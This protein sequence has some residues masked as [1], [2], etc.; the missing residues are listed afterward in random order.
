MVAHTPATATLLTHDT[1]VVSVWYANCA[2]KS[3]FCS[4]ECEPPRKRPKL[5]R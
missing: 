4:G 3:A 1:T 5:R 2:V